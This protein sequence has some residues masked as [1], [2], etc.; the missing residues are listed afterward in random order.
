MPRIVI[1]S[2]PAGTGKTRHAPALARALDCHMIVDGYDGTQRLYHSTLALTKLDPDTL[3]LPMGCEVITAANAMEINLI[4]QCGTS[5]LRKIESCKS[6][7]GG[8]A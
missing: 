3:D 7:T 5:G 6:A 4:A 1:L 2:A 8:A